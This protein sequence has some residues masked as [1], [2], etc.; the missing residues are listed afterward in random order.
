MAAGATRAFASSGATR[1]VARAVALVSLGLA[2][3]LPAA[4]QVERY[5]VDPG[6]TTPGFAVTHLGIST[7][8]GRFERTTGRIELDRERGAGRIE[9]DIETASVSTGNRA[10]D[11]VLKGEDFFDSQRHPRIAFRSAEV[12]FEAGVPRRA[13][14]EL[15]L[16]GR[17][18]PVTLAIERFGCTR[19]PFFVRTTCGADATAAIRRSAFGLSAWSGFVGD[20]VRLEIQVE[21]IREEPAAEPAVPGG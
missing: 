2:A 5:A 11:A 20:E 3:A 1:P 7:Q 17:T 8:R 19:L 12:D 15:T 16:A 10:L 4:A 9:I 21:A 18:Q 14:G 6:H 13:R